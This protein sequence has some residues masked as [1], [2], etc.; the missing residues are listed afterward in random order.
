MMTLQDPRGRLAGRKARML[1]CA[2]GTSFLIMLDANI[3]AVT[4]PSIARD[5]HGEFTD[6]EGVV[7]GYLLPFAALLIATGA[8]ADRLGRR[9]ILV[10]G[11]SIFTIASLLCGLAPTL[12]ALNAARALQ[13]VG[14][15]LQLSAALAIISHGFQAHERARAHAIWGTVMGVAPSMGPLVGGLIAS[16]FGWRWA[17][18]VN[19][20]IGALLISVALTSIDE[21][22]DPDAGRLDF[23][24][25]ALFGGGLSSIVWALI[26]AN[27]AGWG[28]GS[29]L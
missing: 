19:I 29:T 16:F 22:R 13:A 17:F 7:S 28:G 8:L 10:W 6:V 14:A 23:A 9:R 1:L 18:L 21:S 26:E 11:L 4:L 24:G 20:P 27:N 15:A 3:V 25:I 2:A 12:F 5:L